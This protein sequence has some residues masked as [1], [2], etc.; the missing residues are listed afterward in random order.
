MD[1]A[2]SS[3]AQ[4]RVEEGSGKGP[5]F[6]PLLLGGVAAGG[7]GF[8]I[9]FFGA[10]TPETPTMDMSRVDALAAELDALKA[11]DAPVVDF[12]GVEAVQADLAMRIDALTTRVDALETG[13]GGGTAAV[14]ETPTAGATDALRADIQTLS[15]DIGTLRDDLTP[16]VSALETDLAQANTLA[17]SVESE[18]EARALEAARNQV[19][20]ALQSGA[21]YAEALS[22][23]GDDAPEALASHAQTGVAPQA[24]LISAFPDLSREALRAARAAAP[25]A[26]VGSLFT[27]AFNPRSL[28]PREGD[29]PDAVLSR[30][31]AA[32]REGDLAMALTEID[33]LPDEAKVVLDPWIARA[34]A[35]AA[36]LLAADNYLQ[37]G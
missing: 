31:E 34:N 2:L 5:A 19:R 10:S 1:G 29:D 18:A 36:A 32:V 8:A 4:S 14:A 12:S 37:D 6:L 25:A 20:M 15:D 3:A 11:S 22:V 35:R 17:A 26:G 24:S 33:G 28:E 27:N 30:A 9:A 23:L 16:R 13:Q 21:P 7:I